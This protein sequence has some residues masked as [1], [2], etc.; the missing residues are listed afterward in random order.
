MHV[1]PKYDLLHKAATNTTTTTGLKCNK[2]DNVCYGFTSFGEGG[3]RGLKYVFKIIAVDCIIENRDQCSKL[4]GSS[5]KIPKSVS[6]VRQGDNAN[7]RRAISNS[8]KY[9]VIIG[10]ELS[11]QK[12]VIRNTFK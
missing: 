5:P 7:S 2:K 10:N 12:T 9:C 11:F 8:S 1:Y 3:E 4:H 6:M